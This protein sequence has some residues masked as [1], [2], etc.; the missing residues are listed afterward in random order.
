MSGSAVVVATDALDQRS[1]ADGLLD[2]SAAQFEVIGTDSDPNNPFAIDMIRMTRYGGV[3]PN[4][5]DLGYWRVF[6]L[7]FPIAVDTLALARAEWVGAVNATAVFK[8]PRE[9]IL[10]VLALDAPLEWWMVSPLWQNGTRSCEPFIAPGIDRAPAPLGAYQV[11][12]GISRKSLGRGSNGA[13][14]VQRTRNSSRDFEY[15]QPLRRS[16]HRP[17]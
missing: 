14:I 6:G 17:R 16:L 4:G 13:E 5:E 11:P 3:P 8:L 15:A 2:L 7:A 12:R 1:L 10:D 9:S